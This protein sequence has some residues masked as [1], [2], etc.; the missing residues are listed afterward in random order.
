MHPQLGTWPAC[1]LTRNRTKWL[2]SSQADSQSTEPH[3]P[4]LTPCSWGKRVRPSLPCMLEFRQN[5][6]EPASCWGRGCRPA[7][8]PFAGSFPETGFLE[9]V[10]HPLMS[11]LCPPKSHRKAQDWLQETFQV[12]SLHGRGHCPS[13]DCYHWWQRQTWPSAHHAIQ[14]LMPPEHH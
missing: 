4:G 6:A 7:G 14:A 13:L 10:D 3:Q 11:T 2:F 1:A 8:S 5:M 9:Y 12:A